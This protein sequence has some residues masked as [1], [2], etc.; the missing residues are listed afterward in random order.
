MD[1][2][3]VVTAVKLSVVAQLLPLYSLIFSGK[4]GDIC[5]ILPQ[6]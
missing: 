4:F 1:T 2:V 5:T 6:L 3:A